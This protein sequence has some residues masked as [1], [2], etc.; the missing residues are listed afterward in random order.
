MQVPRSGRFVAPMTEWGFVIHGTGSVRAAKTHRGERM[1]IEAQAQLSLW[2][3]IAPSLVKEE[4]DDRGSFSV[5]LP[6]DSLIVT[7]ASGHI[8]LAGAHAVT[9][10]VDPRS[11]MRA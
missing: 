9:D 7:R 11:E 3:R 2:E 6:T 10:T 5:Y 8:S 4:R 1:T